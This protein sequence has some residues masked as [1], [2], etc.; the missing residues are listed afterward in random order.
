VVEAVRHNPDAPRFSI[1]RQRPD[2]AKPDLGAGEAY[3]EKTFAARLSAAVEEIC[4]KQAEIGVDIINDGEFGKTTRGPVD[5]GAW[6]RE[7]G[8]HLTRR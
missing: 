5:Y 3:D 2:D 7:A 8:S 4:R 6:L 1:G